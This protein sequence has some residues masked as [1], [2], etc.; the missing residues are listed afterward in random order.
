[1][2]GLDYSR[3]RPIR[4]GATPPPFAAGSFDVVFEVNPPHHV[5]QRE[6]TIREMARVSRRY[7]ALLEPNRYNP[8]MLAFGLVVKEERGLPN[9]REARLKE[10]ME[11]AGLKITASITAA[12]ISQS[13]TPRALPP[14]L[15]RFDRPVWWGEYTMMVGER[16]AE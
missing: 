14:F 16:Q 7:G 10:E 8:P 3:R 4:D 1:M 9:S 2:L 12:M 13:N 11:T 6:E 5:Q 15:K